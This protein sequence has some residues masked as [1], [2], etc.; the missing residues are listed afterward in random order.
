V[1]KALLHLGSGDQA[2]SGLLTTEVNG[3]WYLNPVQTVFGVVPSVLSGLHPGDI[4]NLI[5]LGH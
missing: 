5:R 1:S 2:S 3:Q 4:T